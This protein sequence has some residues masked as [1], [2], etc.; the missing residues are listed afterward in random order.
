MILKVRCSSYTITAR[1]FSVT[2]PWAIEH[3]WSL[4]CTVK[5][6]N[7][8]FGIDSTKCQSYVSLGGDVSFAKSY[9]VNNPNEYV[10]HQHLFSQNPI[11]PSIAGYIP[12][13]PAKERN[14][15]TS[16]S[17][18]FRI[19]ADEHLAILVFP[20]HDICLP[21]TLPHIS[22]QS[23]GFWRRKTEEGCWRNHSTTTPETP[24][25]GPRCSVF[26]RVP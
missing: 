6:S 8:C 25:W 26:S 21:E 4:R 9:E 22:V 7:G 19:I 11:L 15:C 10:Q 20:S 16:K 12:C 23:S 18:Y 13:R 3:K 14:F 17:S 2:T 5:K 1:T 24:S